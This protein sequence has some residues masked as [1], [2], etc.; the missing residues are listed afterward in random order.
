LLQGF[1]EKDNSKNRSPASIED[2]NL[3]T[4]AN[5]SFQALAE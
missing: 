3:L 5:R 2:Y 4:V 1:G